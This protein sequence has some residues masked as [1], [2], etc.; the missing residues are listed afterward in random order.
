MLKRLLL[1]SVLFF[2]QKFNLIRAQEGY[3][4]F[5]AAPCA[6]CRT[7]GSDVT[8]P[9]P[10]SADYSSYN[11]YGLAAPGEVP[12]D[13]HSG[14][15]GISLPIYVINMRGG[16]SLP[17]SINYDASGIRVTQQSSPIGL[18]WN[19]S[20]GTPLTRVI[21]GG[22]DF[23][24]SEGG[25][26]APVQYLG[27]FN[28]D[29]YN[30]D[31][32]CTRSF[33]NATTGVQINNTFN[34]E[35]D[36]QADIFSFNAG[37]Y[38][39]KF[40]L[41]PRRTTNR[42]VI[43]LVKDKIRIR[44]LYTT[45]ITVPSIEVTTPDGTRYFYGS[46]P[47]I[48]NGGLLYVANTNYQNLTKT[49][50]TETLT[51]NTV[52][53]KTTE[54][55]TAWLLRKVITSY[56]E[57]IKFT[58][59]N[60]YGYTLTSETQKEA[61][62]YNALTD[63][64]TIVPNQKTAVIEKVYENNPIVDKIT[65]PMGNVTF[66]VLTPRKDMSQLNYYINQI[67]ISSLRGIVKSYKI[68]QSFFNDQLNLPA[69]LR[70][71]YLRLKFTSLQEFGANGES[72]PPYVFTYDESINCGSFNGVTLTIPSKKSM[73][74]DHW[75]FFNNKNSGQ[76]I[77]KP[78]KEQ[79]N[80]NATICNFDGLDR[81]VDPA[82]LQAGI[83]TK[84]TFP[85]GGSTE[86]TYEP[87]DYNSPSNANKVI[88]GLRI[89]QIKTSEGSPGKDQYKV[90]K[91]KMTS[92]NYDESASSSGV[93]MA[94]I[95]YTR[96]PA[97]VAGWPV[98]RS[99][100]SILPLSA[101]SAGAIVGYSEVEEYNGL[102]GEQGKSVYRFHSMP[103]TYFDGYLN[104]LPL[105]TPN[106]GPAVYYSYCYNNIQ[107]Y[108]PA[109]ASQTSLYKNYMY[110][111]N[112][113]LKESTSF[114]KKGTAFVK[115]VTSTNSYNNDAG[116]D[117]LGI[118]TQQNVM[119]FGSVA[120]RNGFCAVCGS[121]GNCTGSVWGTYYDCAK[122]SAWGYS[123]P[124]LKL[125]LTSTTSIAFDEADP[126]NNYIGKKVTFEYNNDD[127]YQLSRSCII[128]LNQVSAT[129]TV[130]KEYLYPADYIKKLPSSDPII[131]MGDESVTDNKYIHN[132]PVETF[133][134]RKI[135]KFDK[136]VSANV[137]IFKCSYPAKPSS[138]AIIP[139]KTYQL[140]TESPLIPE[141]GSVDN[142]EFF[143]KSVT[144]S[145]ITGGF[146]MD[147]QYDPDPVTTNSDID[148][149]GNVT[150]TSGN[151]PLVTS[152]VYGYNGYLKY[153]TAINATRS[154]IAYTGL[155]EAN[156]TENG[157]SLSS[158]FMDKN[159]AAQAPYVFLGRYSLK[160]GTRAS[161]QVPSQTAKKELT[162]QPQQGKYKFSCYVK[163]D[164]YMNQAAISIVSKRASDG[165][166][167]SI[168]PNIPQANITVPVTGNLSWKY[169]EGII[170]LDYL[171][172]NSDGST[173]TLIFQIYNADTYTNLYVDELRIAPVD[174]QMTS[175]SHEPM[176]GE[177][178]IVDPNNM[179]LQYEYD[180]LKRL[181]IVR[182]GDGNILENNKYIFK[183]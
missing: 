158:T 105:T 113:L 64:E 157:W 27:S 137:T 71:E 24:T 50:T 169:I 104:Q 181:K 44:L 151:S 147:N 66:G 10:S 42:G 26:D 115:V 171:K 8:A 67:T 55:V 21:R 160:L 57:E 130:C 101:H 174:A 33:T 22:D 35:K 142:P 9:F 87:N 45:N 168:Y 75:G 7:G 14:Q 91:Y 167:Y 76:T 114:I 96:V 25:L 54:S 132:I 90:Y 38:S 145:S 135:D 11:Q 126:L 16:Y 155:E 79:V 74:R 86:Y 176:V 1:F 95:M 141:S 40:I 152:S 37:G 110:V 100:T 106:F 118:S 51:D 32:N 175:V 73:G 122:I 29:N 80:V 124:Y 34:K 43:L 68:N 154:Q 62:V 177:T 59:T 116:P 99:S 163:T 112:G 53:T 146:K 81:D 98:I 13:M 20:A 153:A 138:G 183:P 172:K 166:Q 129:P 103:T 156:T 85:T 182:D 3:T 111:K 52:Q 48:N 70:K 131:L 2:L 84:I 170:D 127:H 36:L 5:S 178:A 107:K 133:T 89:K 93:L 164:S 82:Y 144:K 46:E 83:L 72:K 15:P 23:I 58:Y 65:F 97:G 173:L 117:A 149:Y 77:L 92:V 109:Y 162:P 60:A 180:N 159:V 12:V 119:L 39:A 88:G 78:T 120:I 41:E 47:G 56:N 125:K 123:T 17:I 165:A 134:T 63:L 30:S 128:D 140:N 4:P 161:T 6:N 108:S 102:N 139:W 179:I 61:H 69:T 19:L 150:E 148:I 121:N 94:D 31:Q 28:S 18:G 49:E 136:I 143:T